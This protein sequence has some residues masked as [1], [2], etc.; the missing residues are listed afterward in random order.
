MDITITGRKMP[1]TD[2]LRAYAEDF[3]P[4]NPFQSPHDG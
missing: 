4:Y 1:I 2:A 3:H